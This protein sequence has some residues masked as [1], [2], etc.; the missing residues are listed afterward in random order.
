MRKELVWVA[1]VGISFG[2]IIAFGVYRINASIKSKLPQ[3]QSSPKPKETV[4]EFKITLS[5]PENG[6][7]LTQGSVTVSGITKALTWIT[8]SGEAGDYIIQSDE[9]GVFSQEVGLTS[10]INQIKLTAFDP[11][12]AKSIEKVLVVYSSAFQ[13]KSFATPAPQTASD[14][15]GVRDKVAQKVAEAL[16][17]PKAF[18]GVVTDITDSTIQIKSLESE[19]KQISTADDGVTVVNS[20][21]TT[22]KIVKLTDIAIGDFI[23]AMGYVNSNSVLLAQRILITNP[24]SEPKINASLGKVTEVT[25]KVLTVASLKDSQ[26]SEVSP[27]SK[28]AFQLFI[29]GKAE[30]SKL[31]DIT[32]GDLIIYVSAAGEKSETIR[33]IFIVAHPQG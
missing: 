7:V 15:S 33:S 23:V 9:K 20:K 31:S 11:Q 32:Q 18:V 6:D 8:V 21:G 13:E 26:S 30:K 14:E 29:S 12:G 4:S 24:I 27:D 22:S 25:K 2:L 5:K 19:I 1:A 17:K 28:T 16:N 10:G 3:T